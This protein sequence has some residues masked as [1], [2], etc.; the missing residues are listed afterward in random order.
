MHISFS[1]IITISA[2]TGQLALAIV[3]IVR[4]TSNPL[5]VP[6]ALLCL[7]I[8]GWTGAGFAYQRSHVPSWRWLDHALTPWTAPLALQFVLLFV[9]RVRALRGALLV[10]FAAGGALS[11]TACLAFVEPRMQSF[12]GSV[13]W[14]FLLMSVAI[15][16]MVFAALALLRHLRHSVDSTERAGSILLLA[17]AGIGTVLGATEEL[18]RFVGVPPLGDIGMLATTA[19]LSLVALRFR[20]LDN[21]ASLRTAGYLLCLTGGSIVMALIVLRH[22]NGNVALVLFAS[23]TVTLALVGASRRWLSEGANRRARQMQLATLGRFSAQM[24]HDLKNPL[25]ALKGAAQLLSIDLQRESPGV[26]RIAFATL[27]VEQ[28]ERLSRLVDVYGRLAAISPER[29][30]LDLNELVRSVLELEKLQSD[31]VTMRADCASDLEPCQG[32]REMLSRVLENLVR[33][34]MEAMP[35]GG[36][37]IVST[38]PGGPGSGVGFSVRDTG[39]GMD[40]R[41]R[42]RAFDDF[43]TTKASGSGLGLAFVRR[44][45]EAHR[46]RIWLESEPGCGT[47][48]HVRLPVNGGERGPGDGT[49]RFGP[50]H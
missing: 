1:E 32:D 20:L 14:A 25:A 10:S 49:I 12:I 13:P 38:R 30:P 19:P 33:N 3:S 22:V 37:L 23:G 36:T 29:E 16:T 27:M 43:F 48:V 45:I 44:V 11:A 2:C 4:A 47:V 5:A 34:A 42:E 46:G 6:L 18:G 28:A 26:D 41:T 7:D 21:P 17:A 50:G 9:G 35:H 40:A 24:A 15:P 8:F 31:T 39:L